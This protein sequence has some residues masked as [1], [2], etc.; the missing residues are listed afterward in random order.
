MRYP[1][2]PRRAAGNIQSNLIE[3]ESSGSGQNSLNWPLGIE[4]SFRRVDRGVDPRRVWRFA[5][6]VGR[7]G[8]V[9]WIADPLTEA[10][11]TASRLSAVLIIARSGHRIQLL[12]LLSVVG[13]QSPQFGSPSGRRGGGR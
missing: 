2:L 9:G 13:S 1:S 11:V 10:L 7:L 6:G 12:E 8:E 5:P 4:R 3:S